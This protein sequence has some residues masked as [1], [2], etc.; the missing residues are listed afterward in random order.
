MIRLM[1]LAAII[2]FLAFGGISYW[3]W[4]EAKAQQN[5]IPVEAKILDSRVDEFLKSRSNQGS[6]RG[7][8]PSRK[9]YA[10]KVRYTYEIAGTRYESDAIGFISGSSSDPSGARQK[11]AQY[12][13]GSTVTAYVDPQDNE[14][15]LLEPGVPRWFTAAFAAG[16]I[17]WLL[18]WEAVARAVRKKPTP[19]PPTPGP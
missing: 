5:Y 12:P 18:I 16:A 17:L 6:N 1:H 14:V 4:T 2:G 10:A 15:S 7:S 19:A 3:T 13:K 11:V 8:G 9:H